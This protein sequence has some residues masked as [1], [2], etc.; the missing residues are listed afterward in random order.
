MKC[1]VCMRDLSGDRRWVHIENGRTLSA[2]CVTDECRE[3]ADW[4]FWF[5]NRARRNIWIQTAPRSKTVNKG[6]V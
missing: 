1:C 4:R 6:E 5:T 3:Q 2:C